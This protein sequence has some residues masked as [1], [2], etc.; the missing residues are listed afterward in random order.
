MRKF[1]FI[2]LIFFIF[3]PIFAKITFE[4]PYIN[5]NDEVLFSVKQSSMMGTDPYKTLF[6]LKLKDANPEKNPTPITVYPEQMELLENGTVLQIRN[7]YGIAQYS[8]LSQKLK[9]SSMQD[10]I[11]LT[12]LKAIPYSVSPDGKYII[13][14][15]KKGICTGTLILQNVSTKKSVVIC[16]SVINSYNEIPVKWAPDSSIF[17]YEN[18]GFIQ[19]C[20]PDA[21]LRGVEI[22]EKY[23]KIGKGTINSIC[24]TSSKYLSYI[25]DCILY[26]INSKELYTLG[27]YSRIIGQGTAVGRLPFQ[28]NPHSDTFS[29]N[30]DVSAIFVIQNEKLFTYLRT[31]NQTLGYMDVVFS[32][33][34]TDESASLSNSYVFWT[35]SNEPVLWQEKIPYDGSSTRADIFKLGKDSTAIEIISNTKPVLSPDRNKI[36]V[37]ND[38]SISIYDV[39]SLERISDL[40]GEGVVS[41]VWA[42]KNLIYVGGEKTIKKW[43]LVSNSTEIITLSSAEEYFWS[44]DEKSIVAKVSDDLYNQ[45][46]F[47]NGTW[48]TQVS[49]PI[50]EPSTQNNRYRVFINPTSNRY[51]ENTLYVRF[52]SKKATTKAVFAKSVEKN[53]SS[54]KVALV[55]DAYSNTD[56]LPKILSVLKKYNLPATFCVNG[57][58]VRRFP[59]ETNQIVKNGYNCASMFFTTTNLADDS[60]I[61]DEDFIRHGLARNE[62]EFYAVTKKELMLY[63]HAPFYEASPEI[64]NYAKKAGYSYIKS[65][66]SVNDGEPNS[67]LEPE[68]LIQKYFDDLSKTNGG[69]I[70]I[71]VGYS[72]NKKNEPLYDYLDLLICALLDNGFEFV[73]L[74][75]VE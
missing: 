9:W 48:K 41:A 62:D 32:R 29:T 52:L 28:F 8:T 12:S 15:E 55:F 40:Y 60:F 43:S 16:D 30:D 20:N 17:L 45:Y 25:D 47:E 2:F 4:N 50:S 51:F 58:Y 34:Y 65:Y 36:A 67:D 42:S 53:N 18:D 1:F 27:L 5:K 66:H 13:K 70:P 24:W 37:F 22:D 59:L 35:S 38:F 74:E 49:K 75:E 11:S 72:Y 7:R 56:G 10:D 6:Y 14:I 69:I 26:K 64:I 33:P 73:L 21:I 31:R 23:R 68:V 3:N 54:K 71:C 46:S 61:I 39:N 44:D 63:W 19:F 57:E